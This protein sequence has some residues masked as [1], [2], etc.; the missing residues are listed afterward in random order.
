MHRALVPL[1]AAL[2]LTGCNLEESVA[3]LVRDEESAGVTLTVEECGTDDA[4]NPYALVSMVSEEKEWGTVLFNV[5]MLNED[6]VVIGQGST[7]FRS[8]E[9]GKRYQTK[10]IISFPSEDPPKE[11]ACEVDLE[12]ASR[13]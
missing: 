12:F 10:V 1:L 11:P 6:G 3:G 9:P 8:V 5:E 7:S 13:Q 4:E 2:F